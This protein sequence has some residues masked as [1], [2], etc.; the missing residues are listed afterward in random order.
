MTS[1]VGKWLGELL[2]DMLGIL[3]SI[4]FSLRVLL[5]SFLVS[6]FHFS[7]HPFTVSGECCNIAYGE[8][9]PRDTLFTLSCL[10][11]YVIVYRKLFAKFSYVYVFSLPSREYISDGW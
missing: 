10:K 7:K 2:G 4:L 8:L 5:D 6:L 1:L 9:Y 11:P 3:F